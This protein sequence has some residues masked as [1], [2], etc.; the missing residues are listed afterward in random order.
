MELGN[1][2]RIAFS[3][4]VITG[5]QTSSISKQ[6]E[7][8]A[9]LS[10]E[11]QAVIRYL[12]EGKLQQ[13]LQNQKYADE[14]VSV[15]RM[16][17]EEADCI[18]DKYDQMQQLVQSASEG[19]F[20]PEELEDIQTEFEQLA[21][22]IND[23]VF[24]TEYNSNKLFSSEGL[25]ITISIGNKSSID[26]DPTDL[27]IDTEGLD[28]TSDA[29]EVLWAI[30]SKVSEAEYYSGYLNT[31]VE[32]LENMIRLIEFDIYNDLGIKPDQFDFD[33]AREV[34][35]HASQM[36]EQEIEELFA[37]QTNVDSATVLQLLK[38]TIEQCQ[39]G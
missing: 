2:V 27:S 39:E 29:D 25:P 19:A 37:R 10:D 31:K 15:I 9:L 28:L 17:A 3:A 30:Q 14:A 5:A 20:L 24:E 18:S 6:E 23:L 38:D 8:T 7:G 22:E 36:T 32:N 4:H 1:L 11:A 13:D 33:L 16:F 12:N 21:G 35:S 26:V 34:A